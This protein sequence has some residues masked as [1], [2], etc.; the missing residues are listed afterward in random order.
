MMNKKGISEAVSWVLLLGFSIALA[1]T[2]FLWTTRQTEDI[3]KSTTRY[4]EG[5]MQCD[6]VMINVAK[7]DPTS[8]NPPRSCCLKVTN[9]RYLNIEKVIFRSL[10]KLLSAECDN[11]GQPLKATTPPASMFCGQDWA[12]SNVT[13]MPIVTVDDEQVGCTNKAITIEC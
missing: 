5:G 4:I 9:T 6:N 2:V 11:N 1:T 8:C 3:T 12:S 10:E 7:S 13:V